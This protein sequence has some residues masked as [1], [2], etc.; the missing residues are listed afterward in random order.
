[1]KSLS[2][3]RAFVTLMTVFAT[4]FVIAISRMKFGR[5]ADLITDSLKIGL[6]I[7]VST[8]MISF[9]AWTLTQRKAVSVARGAAAGVMSS[10]LIIPIPSAVWT[11]KT[12]TLEAYQNTTNHIVEAAIFSIPSAINSGLYTFIDISKASLIAVL[13]SLILGVMITL[14][15][16]EKPKAKR[17]S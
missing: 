4:P 14:Y 11:L 12:K 13:A 7:A 16:P 15:V 6:L 5:Q 8:A 3:R 1:M 17:Q 10:L 9:A 2:Q